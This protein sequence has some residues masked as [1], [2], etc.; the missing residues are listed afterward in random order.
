MSYPAYDPIS[1]HL[2]SPRFVIPMARLSLI[3]SF[4]LF[5]P[6]SHPP[7]LPF[8]T[9]QQFQ[10]FRICAHAMVTFHGLYCSIFLF[11]VTQPASL[12]PS[13]SF[14]LFRSVFF[15]PALRCLPATRFAGRPPIA[16]D[17]SGTA[18]RGTRDPA[19]AVSR[20][21]ARPAA[22]YHAEH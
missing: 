20:H 12:S 21:I 5:P 8:P 18:I 9:G 7:S 16:D 11:I 19:A 4:I 22:R 3:P 15:T 13:L 10:I 2:R 6:I 1:L 14:S 17:E